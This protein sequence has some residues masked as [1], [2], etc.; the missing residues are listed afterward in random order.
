MVHCRNVL[1]AISPDTPNTEN[2]EKIVEGIKEWITQ[3]SMH[4]MSAMFVI[5]VNCLV[6]P[7]QRTFYMSYV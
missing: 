6:A 5:I 2:N 1:V 7:L 4:M 3:G